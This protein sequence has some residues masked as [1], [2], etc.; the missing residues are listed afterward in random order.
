MSKHQETM[1][2]ALVALAAKKKG[3]KRKALLDDIDD[4]EKIESDRVEYKK[5][6][7]KMSI[8]EFMG[9]FDACEANRAEKTMSKG[10]YKACKEVRAERNDEVGQMKNDA[11]TALTRM[12]EKKKED[13][14]ARKKAK[15]EAE[16]ERLNFG[17]VEFFRH[18]ITESAMGTYED[19]EGNRIKVLYNGEMYEGEHYNDGK[20]HRRS[21]KDIRRNWKAS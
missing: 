15:K 2:T 1:S 8:K 7:H 4:P 14:Q 5:V 13:E 9:H 12:R 20:K 3:T 19:K 16:D 18:G 17:Y 11:L 21:V 10:M 6:F